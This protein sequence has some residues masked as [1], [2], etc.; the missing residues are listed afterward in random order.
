MLNS[1]K[2]SSDTKRSQPVQIAATGTVA[3]T[4]LTDL[5]RNDPS[6]NT[7]TEKYI[8]P[9]NRACSG[10]TDQGIARSISVGTKVPHTPTQSAN[11]PTAQK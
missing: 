11:R 7:I 6:K 8:A 10:G 5:A 2:C 1:A 4:S 9:I 3:R